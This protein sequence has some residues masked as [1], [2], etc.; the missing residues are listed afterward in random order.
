MKYTKAM[1]RARFYDTMTNL[2][3]SYEETETLRRAEMTL[4]RWAELECGDGNGYVERDEK[5]GRPYYVNC[6][7]RFVSAND[8]RARHAIPDREKGAL[9]RVARIMANHPGMV[10]YHQ[11]DPRG[12][13]L[14]IVREKDVPAGESIDAYYTRGFAVCF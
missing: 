7:A 6:N 2:G 10:A 11:G 12:C 5:T 13:A 4:S 9:A 3:F 14:Y 8:P 1:Q